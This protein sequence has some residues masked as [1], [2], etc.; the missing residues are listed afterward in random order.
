HPLRAAKDDG[1]A[2]DWIRLAVQMMG[3]SAKALDQLAR[4]QGRVSSQKVTVE[5]V[6]VAAGGQAIVGAVTGGKRDA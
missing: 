1:R 6:N 2:R 5:H 4:L 3:A